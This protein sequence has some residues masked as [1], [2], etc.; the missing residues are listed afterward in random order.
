MNTTCTVSFYINQL[1]LDVYMKRSSCKGHNRMRVDF[2]QH[3]LL[4]TLLT[5]HL[6]FSIYK[7]QCVPFHFLGFSFYFLATSEAVTL[8]TLLANSILKLKRHSNKYN[9]YH[10]RHARWSLRIAQPVSFQWH[11]LRRYLVL[12]LCLFNEK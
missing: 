11:V 9:R 6:Y 10:A 5:I 8:T 2:H 12:F 3:A 7:Q 1:V 4:D